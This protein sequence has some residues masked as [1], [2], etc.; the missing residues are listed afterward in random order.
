[1]RNENGMILIGFPGVGKST[2]A[3]HCDNVI[4][5]ESSLFNID[6]EKIENWV[7]PYCNLARWLSHCGFTVCVSSHEEI[8][9]ELERKPGQ[10]Q[11]LIY[12]SLELKD[13]WIDKLKV[14]NDA[15]QNEKTRRSYEYVRD[16]YESAV[17]SMM[18]Q[19]DWIFRHVIISNMGYYLFNLLKNLQ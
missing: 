18:R 14:R 11:V 1:M 5:L 9:R 8:R 2:L 6:G 7:I 19:P 13:K 10:R 12:P 4:D 16:N 15:A 3:Y 17:N